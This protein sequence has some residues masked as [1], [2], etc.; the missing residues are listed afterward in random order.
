MILG[1]GGGWLLRIAAL[2]LRHCLA[3]CQGGLRAY[4]WALLHTPTCAQAI[5]VSPKLL[6]ALG[7]HGRGS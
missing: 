5:G 4:A 1:G 6:P 7:G 2:M 3:I